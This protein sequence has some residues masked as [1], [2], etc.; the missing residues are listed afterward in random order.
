MSW[1]SWFF[2]FE[3]NHI[4]FFHWSQMEMEMISIYWSKDYGV[5]VKIMC[6]LGRVTTYLTYTTFVGIKLFVCILYIYGPKIKSDI[7]K[8]MIFKIMVCWDMDYSSIDN[9]RALRCDP[10]HEQQ[11]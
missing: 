1:K 10:W 2:S 4:F 11:V 5:E 3:Y 6:I 7:W 9:E 8:N